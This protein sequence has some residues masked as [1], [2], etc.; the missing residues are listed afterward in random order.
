MIWY[1]HHLDDYARD[2][3]TLT[4]IQDGAYRRLLDS[5]YQREGPLPS[6]RLMIYRMC[7]AQTSAEKH[8]I[9]FI[10][11]KHFTQ[12]NGHVLNTRADKEILKYQAQCAA[13]RRPNQ[14]R[15][16]VRIDS[17]SG[18]EVRSKKLEE[19]IEERRR[20]SSTATPRKRG[21]EFVLPDWI[22]QEHWNAWVEA[23]IKRRNAPTDWAKEL[24]VSK[25][26]NL[27]GDGHSPAAVLAQSAFRGWA[28]LFPVKDDDR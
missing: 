28:G 25:L 20:S 15:I 19:K 5:Y 9:D 27:R 2:T 3:S 6:D 13:N 22:P 11:D 23:R 17:E 16:G 12:V 4:M 10:L 1:K 21:S 14:S 26:D 24:A 8:A 7:R 18:I